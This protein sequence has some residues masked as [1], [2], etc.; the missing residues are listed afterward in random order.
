MCSSD[1]YSL[2]NTNKT[3]KYLYF[4]KVGASVWSVF[5]ERR[6]ASPAVSTDI[7]IQ[8]RLTSTVS[9]NSRCQ[10]SQCSGG[11]TDN[12]KVTIFQYLH[13]NCSSLVRYRVSSSSLSTVSLRLEL[14]TAEIRLLS[15]SVSQKEQSFS[16]CENNFITLYRTGAYK[17]TNRPPPRIFPRKSFK[18]L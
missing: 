13:W 3:I 5:T 11:L 8:C 17:T 9:V 14:T 15:K 10:C 2:M 12:S 7:Y 16:T 1:Y 4:N 18:K 6:F